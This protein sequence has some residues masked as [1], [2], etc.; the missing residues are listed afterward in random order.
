LL[1][2]PSHLGPEYAAQ[3][4]DDN[5]VEAYQY[6]PNY[7]PET[8]D[9][10][11][12]LIT[13]EPRT[14]LDVGC[15]TGYIARYL[16]PYVDRVDAVDISARMIAKG[17]T[18]PDGDHPRLR[19]LHGAIEDVA[20]SPP[21][22]LITAGQ[23]LH[24]MDWEMVFDRFRQLLT[25]DGFLAI[26][27]YD[28]AA[29]AWNGELIEIINHYSTNREY[30]PY[31]LIEELTQRSLFEQHGEKQTKPV[32]LEQT[33]DAYVE[34]FHARNGFSRNRMSQQAADEFDASAKR[35]ISTCCPDGKVRLQMVGK[36]IWGVPLDGNW[37]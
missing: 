7:P 28:I 21:Y 5:V 11:G 24:W 14:V 19:W 10:L 17:Q 9:I 35:L 25:A 2:K 6:R 13:A 1:P 32:V 15:G 4:D 20:L 26:V 30:R 37:S 33:I 34:S 12:E 31:N 18:L 3:F 16:A 27:E 8:F 23:S 29:A 22:A 36:V